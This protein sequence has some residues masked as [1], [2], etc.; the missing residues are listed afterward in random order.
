MSRIDEIK[1]RA[2]AATP[3]PWG[4]H[5]FGRPGDEEPTSII[6]HAGAFDWRAIND[7]DYVAAMPAWER[8]CDDDALFIAHARE[9]IPWLLAEIERLKAGA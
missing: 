5:D 4:R 8:P 7:G 9:D 1:A 3:G 2:E 6:V